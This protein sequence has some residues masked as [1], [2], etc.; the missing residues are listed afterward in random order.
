[1]KKTKKGNSGKSSPHSKHN[2]SKHAIQPK[3]Q[4]KVKTKTAKGG[5]ERKEGGGKTVVGD[6]T[7]DWIG[8]LVES[9]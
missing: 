9:T 8:S 5:G 1:M 2:K 7:M 6:D 4:T 3:K